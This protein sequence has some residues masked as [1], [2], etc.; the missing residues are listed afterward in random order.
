MCQLERC[1]LISPLALFSCIVSTVEK[2]TKMM[3]IKDEILN[4]I[5]ELEQELETLNL[6]DYSYDVVNSELEY[7]Y[8]QLKNENVNNMCQ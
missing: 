1:T 4:K 8:G 2:F 5:E 7:L 6:G 3:T